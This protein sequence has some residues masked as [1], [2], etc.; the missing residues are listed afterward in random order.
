MLIRT[1]YNGDIR[2]SGIRYLYE[3]LRQPIT[4]KITKM[5]LLINNTQVIRSAVG[6][7]KPDINFP[8]AV[9]NHIPVIIQYTGLKSNVIKRPATVN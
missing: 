5:P 1:Q 6:V 4:F 7:R 8:S 3:R 2:V 9:I